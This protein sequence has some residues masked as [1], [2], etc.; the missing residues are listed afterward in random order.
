MLAQ[1]PEVVAR[2]R[3]ETLHKIGNIRRPSYED[4]RD[5]KYLRAFINE[6]LRLCPVVPANSRTSN[7]DT[8]LPP[9]VPG[10]KP[11]YV[12]ANTRCMYS[13]FVMHRRTDL[14][15]PD[16]QEFDPDRFLDERLH[17]YLVRNPF[18]FL[19]FNAG[20][21]ICLGQQFAYNEV[22]FFLIRLLQ[23]FSEFSLAL[24]AQ[25]AD[26]IPPKHWADCPGRK[27]KEKIMFGS[28]LTMYAKGGLW[29]RM[30]EAS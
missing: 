9:A 16:A 25:P 1:Y 3:Q 6:V 14:W 19:P 22:S 13:V 10:G 30:K 24:D 26:S 28:H 5:M 18:M 23:N 21:R 8:T 20:P 12:P 17:K 27:G 4:I 2:L 7:K 29:V 15:G 11:V